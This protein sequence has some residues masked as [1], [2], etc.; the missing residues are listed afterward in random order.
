MLTSRA[1][2]TL[3]NGKLVNHIS[4]DVSRID[5]C[6]GFFHMAWTAPVQL[7][8]VIVILLVNIGVSALAGVA[9]M[10]VV[11]P[12]QAKAMRLMFGFRRKAMVWTDQRAKLIQELL[13]GIKV[14]KFFAWEGKWIER[15]HTERN[16]EL[17]WLSK[18]PEKKFEV[19]RH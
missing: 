7:V 11:T 1:R 16:N 3:T 12:L 17:S 18:G 14:L 5:F 8:V 6:L 19:P 13:G 9:L 15:V 4:T 2:L 10:L